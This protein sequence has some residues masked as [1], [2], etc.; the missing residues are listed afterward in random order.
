MCTL[1]VLLL[2]GTIAGWVLIINSLMAYDR[3]EP[4]LV[5]VTITLTIIAFIAFRQLNG[6]AARRGD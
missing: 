2:A 3:A 4:W 1:A 5:I 6:N